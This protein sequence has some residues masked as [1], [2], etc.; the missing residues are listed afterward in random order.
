[1]WCSSK[2]VD[3]FYVQFKQKEPTIKAS[4]FIKQGEINLFKTHG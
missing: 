4:S 1:M 2:K 3:D